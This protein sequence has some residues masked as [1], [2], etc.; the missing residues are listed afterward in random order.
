MAFSFGAFIVPGKMRVL[1][2]HLYSQTVTYE[3]LN[4]QPVKVYGTDFF[5]FYLRSE[6]N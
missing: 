2:I 5:L 6:K 1:L 3:S 4:P